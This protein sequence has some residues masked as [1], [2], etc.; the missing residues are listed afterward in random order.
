MSDTCPGK[1]RFDCLLIYT[2][3]DSTEDLRPFKIILAEILVA[4]EFVS[5]EPEKL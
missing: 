5:W 1:V 3:S 2:F 4:L